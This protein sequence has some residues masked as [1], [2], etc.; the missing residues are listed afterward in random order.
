MTIWMGTSVAADLPLDR[1][2]A[3]TTPQDVSLTCAQLDG[4]LAGLSIYRNRLVI[5]RSEDATLGIGRYVLEGDQVAALV[6]N[7]S[8]TTTLAAQPPSWDRARSYREFLQAVED[9]IVV[10]LELKRTQLCPTDVPRV[11]RV[12]DES[13]LA[14]LEQLDKSR[15]KLSKRRYEK[16]RQYI[17]DAIR[18]PGLVPRSSDGDLRSTQ[19]S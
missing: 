19:G 2:A 6:K 1:R 9:R 17:F 18:R 14:A 10:S 13:S 12:S 4:D 8:S 15:N 11:S 5:S 3:A 16:E 7:I